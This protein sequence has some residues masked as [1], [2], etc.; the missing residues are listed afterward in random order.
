MTVK[1]GLTKYAHTRTQLTQ[2]SKCLKCQYIGKIKQERIL[3]CDR[4]GKSGLN[5]SLIALK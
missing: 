3:K 1:V 2:T 4:T 5:I